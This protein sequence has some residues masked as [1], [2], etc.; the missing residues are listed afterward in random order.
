MIA[1]WRHSP[2]PPLLGVYFLHCWLLPP[3]ECPIASH[4]LLGHPCRLNPEH[5]E[6]AGLPPPSSSQAVI[7]SRG[8]WLPILTLGLVRRESGESHCS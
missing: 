3:A 2:N 1:K 7:D 6:P 8:Q 4:L 5:A